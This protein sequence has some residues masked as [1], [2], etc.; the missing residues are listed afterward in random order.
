MT[1]LIT[2]SAR[3]YSAML[4]LY[5]A[6]L[7]RDFGAEMTA[8]FA[9]DLAD[10]WRNSG[11]AGA[12]R[13]WSSA[14]LDFVQVAVP[15]LME[16]PSIA[17]P[18][19]AF[20]LNAAVVGGE[21]IMLASRRDPGPALGSVLCGALLTAL[22]SFVAVRVG[23]SSAPQPLELPKCLKSATSPNVSSAPLLWIV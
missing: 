11:I 4:P 15:G 9:E 12:L 22:T 19:L 20:L 8:V 2:L 18:V 10:A 6:E 21:I 13:V 17:V 5:P 1:A 16:K 7:R 14:A 23:E 3:A